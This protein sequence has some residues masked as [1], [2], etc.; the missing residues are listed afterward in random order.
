ILE[1]PTGLLFRERRL[2]EAKHVGSEKE[3]DLAQPTRTLVAQY[4]DRLVRL[5]RVSDRPAERTAHVCDPPRRFAAR[6]PGSV[7]ERAA[8]LPRIVDR[9]QE[10]AVAGLDV[11]D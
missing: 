1:P 10:R 8:E 4:P 9:F 2:G 11:E 6:R 5:E 3:A 7:H